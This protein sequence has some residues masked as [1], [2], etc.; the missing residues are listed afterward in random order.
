M[1]KEEKE[2]GE[3]G[4]RREEREGALP[5]AGHSSSFHL[6]REG[7]C[8]ITPVWRMTMGERRS[9]MKDYCCA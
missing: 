2:K 8:L 3:K 5:P 9:K 6:Q 1:E 4:Q 7:K